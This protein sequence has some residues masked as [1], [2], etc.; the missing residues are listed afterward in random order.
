MTFMTGKTEMS[1]LYHFRESRFILT[2]VY[3]DSWYPDFIVSLYYDT[4]TDRTEII[5]VRSWRMRK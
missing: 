4:R 1:P 5:G 3:S 2:D